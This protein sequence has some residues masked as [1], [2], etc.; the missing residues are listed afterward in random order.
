MKEGTELDATALG[1][2]QFSAA[3]IVR[4]RWPNR[5]SVLGPVPS[6]ALEPVDQARPAIRD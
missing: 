1:R 5:D 2:L 4:A 3:A 6:L